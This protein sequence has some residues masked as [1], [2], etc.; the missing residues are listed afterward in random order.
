MVGVVK[1]GIIESKDFFFFFE[2]LELLP[3]LKYGEKSGD[4]SDVHK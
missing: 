4:W 1:D 2:G 3:T